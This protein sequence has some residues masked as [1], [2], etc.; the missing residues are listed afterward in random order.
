MKLIELCMPLDAFQNQAPA[1]GSPP[2]AAPSAAKQ[3]I[4]PTHSEEQTAKEGGTQP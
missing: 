1:V 2:V 3:E 4:T